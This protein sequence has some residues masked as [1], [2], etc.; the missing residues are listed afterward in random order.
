MAICENILGKE[1]RKCK[2]LARGKNV[3]RVFK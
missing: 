2:G 3:P 1:K